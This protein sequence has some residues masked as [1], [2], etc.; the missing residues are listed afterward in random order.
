M[1]PVLPAE[2]GVSLS[3]KMMPDQPFDGANRL[4]GLC[5][6]DQQRCDEYGHGAPRQRFP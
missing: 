2:A 4:G 1:C 5:G 3:I 6:R